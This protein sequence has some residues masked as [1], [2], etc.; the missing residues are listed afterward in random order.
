MYSHQ[1][2]QYIW[3]HTSILILTH[4]E[5]SVT[6]GRVIWAF[7]LPIFQGCIVESELVCVLQT[8]TDSHTQKWRTQVDCGQYIL[9]PTWY[10]CKLYLPVTRAIVSA[11]TMLSFCISVRYMHTTHTNIHTFSKPSVRYFFSHLIYFYFV[12]QWLLPQ[13]WW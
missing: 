1:H 3:I 13:V 11:F 8:H 9:W 6:F 4:Y 7:S 12:S 10:S 5:A 2:K